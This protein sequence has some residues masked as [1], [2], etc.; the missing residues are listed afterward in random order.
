[1]I[2]DDGSRDVCNVAVHH[3]AGLALWLLAV[4]ARS[5]L[6]VAGLDFA[7]RFIGIADSGSMTIEKLKRAMA[8]ASDGITE[9]MMHPAI[10]TAD[11]WEIKRRYRWA[12]RYKFEDEFH[13][14]C[15]I[16]Q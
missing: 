6:R 7:D 5:M 14:L 8:N 9:I 15:A 16:N 11:V 12:M 10:I 13:A 4:R 2:I 3:M 1:M